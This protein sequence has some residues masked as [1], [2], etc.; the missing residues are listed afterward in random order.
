MVSMIKYLQLGNSSGSSDIFFSFFSFTVPVAPL[1]VVLA[2]RAEVVDVRLEVELEDV[3]LVNVL[4]LGGDGDRVAQQ[5]EAGQ[6]VVVLWSQEG[7][8]G[9]LK[10]S[11]LHLRMVMNLE[12]ALVPHTWCD[13]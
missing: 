7:D 6:G 13:L 12:S 2:L 9:K 11:L 5:G 10:G 8:G 1:K 3:V 4:R